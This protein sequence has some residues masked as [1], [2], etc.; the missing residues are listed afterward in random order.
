M[1]SLKG[2]FVQYNT[3]FPSS[4]AVERVLSVGGAVLSKKRGKMIDV[5]FDKTM[6]LKSNKDFC[7]YF[8]FFSVEKNEFYAIIHTCLLYI[9]TN[10]YTTKI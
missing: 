5:N 2:V 9:N 10:I 1:P 8:H 6:I 7:F 3:P 4:A